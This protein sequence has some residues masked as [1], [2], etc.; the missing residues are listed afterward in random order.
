MRS[1]EERKEEI[2]R[3]SEKRII[4]RKK[5]VKRVVLTCVPLVLC[6]TV[7][8]GY[9]TLGGFGRMDDAAPESA[10]E[11]NYGIVMD[12]MNANG[13][14]PE[15]PEMADVPDAPAG[16]AAAQLVSVCAQTDGMERIHT[17]QQI[18]Q[19]LQDLL[20]IKMS[21]ADA[22]HY[23]ESVPEN[24]DMQITEGVTSGGQGDFGAQYVCTLTLTYEDGRTVTYTVLED[25]I[26]GAES[27]RTLTE[28]Q[29]Q[30][31][32]SLCEEETP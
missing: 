2:F 14:V 27:I 9:L 28:E 30:W 15:T 18:L 11:P 16:M 24:T 7:V 5:I 4:Q 3:R 6:L 10:M 25:R 12:S 13:A 8:S 22:D 19:Q 17:D 29:V 23:P 1:F 32:E 26:S 31:L 20:P 21:S